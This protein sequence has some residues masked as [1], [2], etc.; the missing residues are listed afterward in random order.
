MEQVRTFE[1]RGPGNGRVVIRPV[2]AADAG[3]LAA[4]FDG[5]AADDRQRRFFQQYHPRRDFIERMV[6]VGERGGAAFVAV[7]IDDGGSERELLGEAGFVVLPDGNGELAMTVTPAARGWLGPHLLDAVCNNAAAHGVANLEADVLST[8]RA[9]LALLRSRGSVSME[10]TGWSVVRLLIGTSTPTPSWPRHHDHLRVLVETPSGRWHAEAEARTAGMQVLTCSG[11][12]ATPCP[13]LVGDRCALAD[14]ADVILVTRPRHD[15]S[16][17]QL[18][19][20]HAIAHPDVAV[21][22]EPSAVAD[23]NQRA[24]S[25]S[26]LVDEAAIVAVVE[27]LAT[28][29]R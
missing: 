18:L 29:D 13:A 14:S 28:D 17:Q 15:E 7:A 16:W 6:T 3:K 12:G 21:C 26:R 23:A 10:H 25:R 4:L 22:V 27:R 1:V 20:S 9:M 2:E 8:D 24:A 11:P 5:L 19:E